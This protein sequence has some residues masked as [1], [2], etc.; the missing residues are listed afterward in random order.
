MKTQTPL[1]VGFVNELFSCS[2]EFEWCP[3]PPEQT[4][5]NSNNCDIIEQVTTRAPIDSFGRVQVVVHFS[6]KVSYDTIRSHVHFLYT[7]E[8]P[9]NV[10][11]TVEV[12]CS[13]IL[14]KQNL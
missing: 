5:T 3:P 2:S 14:F 6:D 10:T 11:S 12:S 8:L 9:Q 13:K 4:Q 1:D 7:G